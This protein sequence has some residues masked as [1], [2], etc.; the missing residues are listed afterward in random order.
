MPPLQFN[1]ALLVINSNVKDIE[2]LQEHV[3]AI[4]EQVDDNSD[5]VNENIKNQNIT[6]DATST[7]ATSISDIQNALSAMND[8]LDKHDYMLKNM[9][10]SMHHALDELKQIN[11][12]RSLEH[13]Q[14]MTT[15]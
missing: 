6:A 9:Q 8:R 1:E 14:S 12:K 13:T 3:K 11:R 2:A 10:I 5:V 15:E 7:M 4:Q